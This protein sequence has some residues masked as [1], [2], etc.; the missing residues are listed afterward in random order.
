MG[1]SK[2]NEPNLPPGAWRVKKKNKL[3]QNIFIDK[4]IIMKNNLE[5]K[6]GKI[7]TKTS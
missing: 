1:L 5:L 2:Y 3:I 6:I 7:V 4:K